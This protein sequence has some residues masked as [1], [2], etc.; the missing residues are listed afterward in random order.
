MIKQLGDLFNEIICT[1]TNIRKSMPGKQ[2]ASFFDK[3]HNVSTIKNVDRAITY[4]TKKCSDRDI[5]VILGSHFFA[6][7][8]NKFY[9]NCFAIHK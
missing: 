7:S 8:I 4:I 5:I 1:E 3:D 2:L 9:K 6:P